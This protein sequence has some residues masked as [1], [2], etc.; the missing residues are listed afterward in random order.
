M[1]LW[2]KILGLGGGSGKRTTANNEADELLQMLEGETTSAA[3]FTAKTSTPKQAMR[4]VF[5]QLLAGATPDQ[6]RADLKR[7]A[8]RAPRPTPIST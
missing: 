3:D 8:S 1:A 6:L 7:K 2:K 4:Y 5:D